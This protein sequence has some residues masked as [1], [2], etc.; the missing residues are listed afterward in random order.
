MKNVQIEVK[1]VYGNQ[2]IYPVN[3]EARLFA[4]IA[5]KKTFDKKDL[6]A[7]SELGFKLQVVTPEFSIN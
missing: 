3:D 2:L 5:G 1:N 7:I 6:I 4:Q